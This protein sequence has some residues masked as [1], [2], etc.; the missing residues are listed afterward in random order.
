MQETDTVRKAELVVLLSLSSLVLVLVLVCC[1][2][3]KCCPCL[4]LFK[5]EVICPAGREG[6]RE[7]RCCTMYNVH[8]T[9]LLN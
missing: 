2:Q 6:G 4:R 3:C 8:F 9:D 5:L 1:F 7:E